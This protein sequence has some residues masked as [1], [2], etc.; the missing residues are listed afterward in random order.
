MMADEFEAGF[1]AGALTAIVVVMLLIALAQGC[2]KKYE[3][4]FKDGKATCLPAEKQP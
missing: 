1:G 2:Q 4:G 3:Q